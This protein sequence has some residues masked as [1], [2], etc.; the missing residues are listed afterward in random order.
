MAKG[1]SAESENPLADQLSINKELTNYS[2]VLAD[3]PQIY[4]LT[5]IDIVDLEDYKNKLDLFKKKRIKILPI[6]S[7][8]EDGLD[9]LKDELIAK[10]A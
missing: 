1:F 10:G 9:E 4:L 6:S 5:K 3:K 2:E 8:T 7:F